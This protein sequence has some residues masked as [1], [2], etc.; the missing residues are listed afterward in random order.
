MTQGE[1]RS[2]VSLVDTKHVTRQNAFSDGQERGR[3]WSFMMRAY[4]A[5]HVTKLYYILSVL[6]GDK[7]LDTGSRT[8]PVRDGVT[9]WRWMVT[10]WETR[11]FFRVQRTLPAILVIKW[12]ILGTD[13]TQLLTVWTDQVKDYKQQNSNKTSGKC[14]SSWNPTTHDEFDLM[15]A[16]TQAAAVCQ[17]CGGSGQSAKDYWYQANKGSE[18]GKKGKKDKKGQRKS[19][20]TKDTDNKKKGACY[21]CKVVGHFASNC[22]RRKK[23]EPHNASYGGGGDLHCLTYTDDQFQWITMREKVGPVVE[24]S[25]ITELLMDYGAA[26][27][28]RPCRVAAG[29]S[30]DAFRN[31]TD[32]QTTSQGILKAKSQLVEVLGEKVTVKAMFELMSMR[33]PILS[34]DRLVR[35]EVV[36]V[37]ENERR[38]RSY[39]KNR[40]IP[41]STMVCITSMSQ[42]CQ[43][44]A[45]WRIQV[46][47]MNRL[48]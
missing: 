40:E 4:R 12:N 48:Q 34:V 26:S 24:Q 16:E 1:R 19:T 9:R 41:T 31:A 33:C 14:R 27:H 11:A 15:A 10:C 36:V 13:V 35:K 7:A 25:N 43:S 3:T 30:C 18:K 47:S 22:T 39:K 20:R 29:Y 32:T 45:H 44:R 23:R 38:Y 37:M 28:V 5:A 17:V 8:R 46:T 6:L 2:S 42:S 21:N